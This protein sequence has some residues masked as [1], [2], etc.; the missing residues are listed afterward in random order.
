MSPP[1][2]KLASVRFRGLHRTISNFL[3]CQCTTC[4]AGANGVHT[5]VGF[6]WEGHRGGQGFPPSPTDHHLRRRVYHN[7][8]DF[9]ARSFLE[10]VCP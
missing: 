5:T 10:H 3:F 1:K 4:R 7:V 2:M 8:D 6:R 9:L